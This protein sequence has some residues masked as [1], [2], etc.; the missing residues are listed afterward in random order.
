M[1]HKSIHS[2]R[3][4]T[5]VEL[6]VAATITA[7]VATAGATFVSAVSNA[8]LT[9]RSVT[10]TKTAGHYASFQMTKVIRESRGVGQVT[11][12]AVSLWMADTS[13]DDSLNLYETGVLRY[14]S[15]NKQVVLD[16][17]QPANGV[18][19]TTTASTATFSDVTLLTAAM[20][21]A[22]KKSVVWAE[23]IESLT[24]TGQASSVQT[25][26]VEVT[27][28]VNN[29]GTPVAFR[30]AAAPKAPADYL[31]YPET[32]ASP[33]PGS[34]RKIRKAISPWDG[35]TNLVGTVLSAPFS[36]L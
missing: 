1:T 31:F 35:L 13:G 7:L 9:S 16:F 36:A 5:M 26:M 12:N 3:A 34:T 2:F 24:F 20:P 33:L 17:L 10:E 14:D 8:S 32:Q 4:F 25:R 28:T 29:T 21:P 23:N 15:A 6:L 27:F 19:P 30:A 18:A 22:D 11:P